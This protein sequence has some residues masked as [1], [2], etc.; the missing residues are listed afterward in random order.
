M[1]AWTRLIVR[2]YRVLLAF[3]PSGFRAEFGEEMYAVFTTVLT[4]SQRPGGE[5]TWR[6][7]WREIRH[8]PGTVFQEHLRAR[9]RK[10]SMNGFIEEKPPQR[11]ELFAAMTIFLLPLISIFT[12]TNSNFPEWMNYIFLVLFW[13]WIIFAIGLAFSKRF[14]GWSL[15]YLGFVLILGLIIGGTDRIWSW[16]YPYFIQLFGPRSVWPLLIR[17]IY[18][19]LFGFIMMFIIL[20]GALVLV[21]LLRLL[22]YTRSVWQRIRADW[23]QLSFM[24][25]GV[26]V[27]D[28]ILTFDEYRYE[29]IWKFIAWTCLA[30]GAWFYLRGKGQK[31]RILVLIY[32]ATGAKWIVTLAKWIL[33]PLQKWPDGYP[34]APSETTRWVETG[35]E[36]VGW[37]WILIMLLVPAFLSFLPP[38]PGIITSKEE[39]PIVA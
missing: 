9:R 18:V 29:D 27:F 34:I 6:L 37:V 33:I 10:M 1:N 30:L 25:Y 21:N 2:L 36:L 4:E 17:I 28:I 8:W 35:S 13:G 5:R 24:L 7:F 11:A 12:I 22:P 3:Y 20:L 32:G 16:I 26:L 19:G 14:P 39:D 31:R 38:T 15:P 23:T